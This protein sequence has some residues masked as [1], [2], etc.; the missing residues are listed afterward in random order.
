MKE[1]DREIKKRVVE[2]RSVCMH[3]GNVKISVD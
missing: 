1:G 2:S 3:I